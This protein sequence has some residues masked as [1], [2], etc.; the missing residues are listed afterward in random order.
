MILVPLCSGFSGCA[1][2][3]DHMGPSGAGGS[4]FPLCSLQAEVTCWF[5]FFPGLFTLLVED[6]GECKKPSWE[7]SFVLNITPWPFW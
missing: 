2:A 5:C 4:R 1:L 7:V 6:F 3:W